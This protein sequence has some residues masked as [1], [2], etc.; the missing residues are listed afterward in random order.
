MTVEADLS[1]GLPS[2]ELVG[3]PDSAVK[4]AKDRVRSALKNSGFSYPVSRITVK[5]RPGG[6]QKDRPGL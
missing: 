3:L 1:S 5:P 6:H 2:F 4:E